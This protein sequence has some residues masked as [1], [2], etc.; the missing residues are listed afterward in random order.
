MNKQNITYFQAI[1]TFVIA[2]GYFILLLFTFLPFIK[3]HFMLN[4][5][6]YWFITGY[7]LFIPIFFYAVFMVKREGNK[8]FKQILLALNIRQFTKKDWIYT[9]VGLLLVFIGTGLIF[10]ISFLL[11]KYFGLKMLSTTPWFMEIHPFRGYDKL[12]LL[13]WLPMFFLNI[14]GEEILWRG[15]IQNRMQ[16]KYSWFLCSLLWL[17]FHI[18]FGIDLMIMLLPLFI[19]VPYIFY[20]TQNTRVGILIHGIYNGP[21]FIAVALGLIK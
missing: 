8:T 11:H 3:L 2:L 12:L 1:L 6:L 21:I 14:T 9:I 15:Y 13:I 19:I 5:A 20:K 7:F 10:G 17:M 16:G 18:P 4:S